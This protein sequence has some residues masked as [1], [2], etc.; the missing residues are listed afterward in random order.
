M[1]SFAFASR[2]AALVSFGK[3]DS[4]MNPSRMLRK[5]TRAIEHIMRSTSDSALISRL[6]TAH[7][8]FLL[9]HDVLHDVHRQ[10]R[11]AHRRPRRDDDHFAAVQTVRHPVQIREARR[12]PVQRSLAAEKILNRPDGL[13]RPVP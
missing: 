3:S 10:R 8:Q 2:P 6:N 4:L 5:F 7:R 1:N 11:F 9:Q 13:A 12:Q